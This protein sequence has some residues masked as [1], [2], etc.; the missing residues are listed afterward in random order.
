MRAT[1]EIVDTTSLVRNAV[2]MAAQYHPDNLTTPTER[3]QHV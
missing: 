2:E 3:N 1:A